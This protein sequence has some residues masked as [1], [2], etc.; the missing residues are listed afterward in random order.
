VHPPKADVAGPSQAQAACL[1]RDRPFDAGAAGI[2]RLKRPGGF[3]LPGR[4]ERLIL[5]LGPDGERPPGVALLRAYAL[6]YVGTA[7]AIFARELHLDDR[8]PAIIHGRRPADT[9][10]ARRTGRVLLVPIDLEML[11]VK[12]GA[13]ASLPV[14]VSACGPQQIHPIVV[15][16][17]NEEVGVQEAGIHDMRA[18]Q[19][20]PLLQRGMDLGGCR[21]VGCWAGGGFDV[22][23]QVRQIIL[24]G[25]GNM[26]FVADP[27]RGVLTGIVG[28]NVIRGAD[29]LRRRGDVIRLT[30]AQ[31]VPSDQ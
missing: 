7:S 30:P 29:E 2:L 3:P 8:I 17:L 10:L 15:P 27:L 20:A 24:T 31:L 9:R 6:G 22:R 18:R 4:L 16:T 1:A 14:I 13:R 12:A 23:D 26:D 21:A 11:D 19:Q 5:W 25:F 28:F